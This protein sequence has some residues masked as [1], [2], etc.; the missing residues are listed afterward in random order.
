MFI[1]Y[2]IG[3]TMLYISKKGRL[4]ELEAEN[5]ILKTDAAMSLPHT[6]GIQNL[7]QYGPDC[8]SPLHHSTTDTKSQVFIT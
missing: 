1:V 3:H 4:I 6:I 2:E 8:S 7:I 5:S